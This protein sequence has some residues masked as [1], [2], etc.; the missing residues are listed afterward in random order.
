M[1]LQKTIQH[2]QHPFAA[3]M[4]VQSVKQIDISRVHRLAPVYSDEAEL[5]LRMQRSGLI[6]VEVL[7]LCAVYFVRV[8]PLSTG[9]G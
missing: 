7:C 2:T 3:D 4:T 6:A 8:S 5:E 9:S 1:R